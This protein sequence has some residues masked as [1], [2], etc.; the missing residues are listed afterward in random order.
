MKKYELEICVDSVESA[1]AARKGG[2]TRLELCS[3]LVI[4]GTTPSPLLFQE[5]RKYT[6]IRIHVLI[7]PRFG[8]FCYNA[9]EKSQILG[10][11][12]Q[13]RKLGAEG[14]VIGAL[15]TD[16]TIDTAYMKE[17]IQA[18]G[19]MHVTMHRAFD[20]CMDLPAALEALKQLG[21]ATI[22]TS[23]GAN[24]CIDGM[25]TLRTLHERAENQIDIMAG[26]GVSAENVKLLHD[27][28]GICSYHMSGKKMTDS[29]MLYRN[30]SVN[31]GLPGIN[32]YQIIQTDYSNVKAAAEILRSIP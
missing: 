2:A 28:T 21:I 8:D 22:L 20:M 24:N 32:E 31:M 29:P 9:Y 3:N 30:S 16:G 14:I 15:N 23:G 25:A 6:D 5:I 11:V 10:E 13:F 26:A 1:L 18:A 27:S 19:S 7:R 17:L 12:E 4:G